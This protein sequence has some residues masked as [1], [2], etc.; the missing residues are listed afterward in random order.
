MYCEILYY[1]NGQDC[2]AKSSADLPIG[3]I[4]KLY[5]MYE[6]LGIDRFEADLSDIEGT[7]KWRLNGVFY[8][9][10]QIERI[11]KLKAFL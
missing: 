3:W 8:S 6:E 10:A 11:K 4:Q 1:F 7:T 2:G 9:N 5:D